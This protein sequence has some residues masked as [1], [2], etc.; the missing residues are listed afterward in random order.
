MELMEDHVVYIEI[1][2]KIQ[3]EFIAANM[4]LILC[5]LWGLVVKE[6]VGY[7]EVNYERGYGINSFTTTGADMRP[8]FFR[9]PLEISNFSN[10]HPLTQLKTSK[11]S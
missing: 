11:F 8:V 9:A 3:I 5:L 4:Q 1:I 2:F 6:P 10:T 7:G